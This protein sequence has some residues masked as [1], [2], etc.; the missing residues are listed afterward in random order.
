[1]YR[2]ILLLLLIGVLLA[3]CTYR[4]QIRRGL[5]TQP[6]VDERLD[7]SVLVLT[8]RNIPPQILITEPEN[9]DTQAF[10]LQTADGTAVAVT[11]A[12][13]TLFARA[14]AGSADLQNQY[15]FTAEVSLESGLTR[16]NCEG[17]LSKWAVRQDGLCTLL[18]LSIYR[19]GENI[20]LATATASRWQPFRTPGFASSVRWLNEH[21]RI[22]FFILTPLYVQTQG[23]ALRNQFENNLKEVLKDIMKQVEENRAVF[24]TPAKNT[25]N[26]VE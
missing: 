5:Y 26:N 20:P 4:G 9:S 22:F 18:T 21:T 11:D 14:D 6:A 10:V 12:L 3:G 17:T 23:N 25:Q 8:D 13:S 7:A 2:R 15:D 1:M 19:A 16:N 24:T